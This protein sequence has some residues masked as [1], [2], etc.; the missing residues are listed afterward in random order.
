LILYVR[1]RHGNAVRRFAVGAILAGSLGTTSLWSGAAMAAP[2]TVS[3]GT[4]SGGNGAVSTNG[5]LLGFA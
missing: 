1:L 4:D 5:G 2:P 3:L